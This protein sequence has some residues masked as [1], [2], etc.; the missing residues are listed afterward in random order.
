MRSVGLVAATHASSAAAAWRL[1]IRSASSP[2][3]MSAGCNKYIRCRGY[4]QGHGQGRDVAKHNAT[5]TARVAFTLQVAECP[6]HTMQ[7]V[8]ADVPY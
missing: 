8:T 1:W 5:V 2:S 3:C 7:Q 4:V 6:T